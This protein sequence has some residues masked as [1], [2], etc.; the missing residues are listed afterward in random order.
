[1]SN[2]LE[3]VYIQA[4][5]QLSN[6]KLY[7]LIKAFKKRTGYGVLC[8]TSLNFNGRGLINKLDDL[9]LYTIQHK[10]DGFIVNGKV[11]LLKSSQH[12]QDYLKK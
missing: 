10:L 3:I 12:Y 8:N 11:Y 7:N 6:E 1:M 2:F 4:V 9:S 5:S